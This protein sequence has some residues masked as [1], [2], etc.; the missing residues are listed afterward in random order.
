MFLERRADLVGILSCSQRQ[1]K[2][3]TL[4]GTHLRHSITKQLLG[5]DPDAIKLRTPLTEKSP[6]SPPIQ[7]HLSSAVEIL[8][9]DK[10]AL[11]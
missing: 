10:R 11:S 1:A 4:R 6:H 9:S 7:S 3:L 5:I 8:T 2:M